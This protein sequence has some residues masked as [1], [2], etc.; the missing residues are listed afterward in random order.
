[1]HVSATFRDISCQGAELSVGSPDE[2][3][4]PG[5]TVKLQFRLEGK[6]LTI[7]ARVVWTASTKAGLRLHMRDVSEE[8][9]KTYAAWIV[10]LTNKAIAAA[11]AAQA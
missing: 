7:P 4:I 10:P 6:D 11:K 5:T 3:L 1:M 2:Q 8:T 9:R